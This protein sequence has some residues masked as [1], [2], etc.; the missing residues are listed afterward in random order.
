[1]S[2]Y[3]IF[4]LSHANILYGDYEHTNACT[5]ARQCTKKHVSCRGIG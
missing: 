2:P 1:M 5:F 3:R 4:Q